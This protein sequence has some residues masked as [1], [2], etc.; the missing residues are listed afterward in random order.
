MINKKSYK[1]LPTVM[2]CTLTA[3]S[4]SIVSWSSPLEEVVVTAQ[5]REQNAQDIG[6][7]ISAF[8]GNRLQDMGL[9]TSN[10]IA[11]KVPNLTIASPTG[12]GG[13]VVIFVRGVG[14]N[15]FATNNTGPVGVYV[16]DVYAGSSNA[17]VT[18]LLDVDR[19]EVLKGPQGTLFGRNTTGGAV[20]IISKKPTDEVEGYLRGSYGSYE[21]GNDE[22]KLEGAVSGPILDT[23]R[24]RLALVQYQSDGYMENSVTGD[25]VEKESYAGRIL[26]D[27]SPNSDLYTLLNLHGSRNDSD[28]DLYNSSADLDFYKGPSNIKPVLDVK[29]WG[30]SLKAEYTF[31]DTLDLVSITAY[32]YL[33]KLAQ[34]D[35]DMTVFTIIHTDF[36]VESDTWSQEFRLLGDSDKL[37]WISG[38]YYLRDEID[39]DQGVNLQDA[40]LPVPYRYINSQELETWALYGQTELD[41]TDTLTL[42]TGLRYTDVSVDFDTVGSGTF[43]VA[44]G[45]NFVTDY[46]LTD[47][48]SDSAWSGKIGLDWRFADDGL[49][50]ASIAKG[51]KG[52]GVNGNFLIDLAGRLDYDSEDL[53]AY[54]MGIKT[55]PL[56]GTLQI[57]ASIFYYDYSDAQIFN[58]DPV[59]G[60]GLPANT[61]RNA[62]I[63]MSGADL[64]II[65]APTDAFYLQLGLGYLDGEYD[66]DILDPVTGLLPIKGNR[67]QNS[68]EWSA[69][70]LASYQWTLGAVGSITA[71]IDASYS[72]DIY[73]NARQ[74]IV[75][76]QEAY[77]I[78]NAR[79]AYRTAGENLEFAVWAKNLSNKE[80]AAYSFDLRPDFGFVQYMRGVPRT[81]G[82]DV[83]YNF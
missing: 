56:E 66:Q 1:S 77:T 2:L 51:F 32:D 6:I 47:D 62:D 43:F 10:E 44:E 57:N 9:T 24:G 48:V 39:Q 37:N 20:N 28:A 4:F 58:N 13:V 16:D 42:T 55:S 40:G 68:P 65:W 71:M 36:G 22:Y 59:P 27:W 31:A 25:F 79:L 45:G 46:T 18:T 64:D 12:E 19:V 69:F 33:D 50:Y 3:Y 21:V 73:Y 72:D 15:D 11:A 82:F 29:Q 5:K 67:L 26:L 38:F 52:A 8:S 7:N 61:I 34:E 14:L 41:L 70:G 74:D 54:E 63:T 83:R 17:Q 81:L 75:I 49:L 23:V 30:V 35:S 80:Y 53:Y 76:G 60:I 78:T